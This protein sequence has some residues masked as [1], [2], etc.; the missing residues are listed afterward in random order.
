MKEYRPNRIPL[1]E[2]VFHVL[3]SAFMMGYAIYSVRKN[4]FFLRGRGSSIHLRE[5]PAWVMAGAFLCAC[6]VML[7]IVID[8]YD[9]R[10]NEYQ[11][12]SFAKFFQYC[13]WMLFGLSLVFAAIDGMR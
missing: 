6:A 3:A 4:D 5:F 13:G 12:R 11:Y 1:Y 10:N 8:H 9:K 2:R 7:S